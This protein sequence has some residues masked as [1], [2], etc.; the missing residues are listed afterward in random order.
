MKPLRQSTL[1]HSRHVRLPS[2]ICRILNFNLCVC[3]CVCVLRSWCRSEL[4][5]SKTAYSH[6][7]SWADRYLD[8]G[9]S[10]TMDTAESAGSDYDSD[11]SRSS[12]ETVHHSYSYVPSDAEVRARAR[13]R[14]KGEK[15]AARPFWLVFAQVLEIKAEAAESVT[16]SKTSSIASSLRRRLSAFSAKVGLLYL[17]L[18]INQNLFH[19]DKTVKTIGPLSCLLSNLCITLVTAI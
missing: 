12:R 7:A 14:Q 8:S 16:P 9:V 4:N 6:V 10:L 15:A 13:F 18:V 1:D 3:V 19:S 11:D 5:S 17:V 2:W